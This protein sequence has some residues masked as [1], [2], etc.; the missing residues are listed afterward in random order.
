MEQ[1]TIQGLI[2]SIAEAT[3]Y[4]CSQVETCLLLSKSEHYLGSNY[5]PVSVEM[6]MHVTLSICRII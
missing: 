3:K 5:S 4:D 2:L 6:Q 1:V